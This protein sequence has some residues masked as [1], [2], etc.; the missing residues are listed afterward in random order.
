MPNEAAQF[1][2]SAKTLVLGNPA[3]LQRAHRLTEVLFERLVHNYRTKLLTEILDNYATNRKDY[4]RKLLL[5]Y[6]STLILEGWETNYL[7]DRVVEKFFTKDIRKIERRTFERFLGQFDFKFKTF[8]VYFGVDRATHGYFRKLSMPMV[9]AI[10]HGSAPAL[11][12][13]AFK[14]EHSKEPQERFV[15]CTVEKLDRK[16]ATSAALEILD[17]LT[18]L[19]T[20][21][22]NRS[23]FSWSR[24]GY[25]M[26]YRAA[27][28]FFEQPTEVRFQAEVPKSSIATGAKQKKQT[29]IIMRTMKRES[30]HRTLSALNNMAL[31]QRTNSAE[32]QLVLM[33]SAIEML[34]S[35]PPDRMPRIEFFLQSM[36]PCICI[37]YARRYTCSIFDEIALHYPSVARKILNGTSA[38]DGKDDHTRFA[39]FMFHEGFAFARIALTGA[40]ESNPLLQNR[41]WK[42]YENF[43]DPACLEKAVEGHELRVKW[44]ISRIY[45]ARNSLVHG[46][47]RPRYIAPITLNCFEYFKTVFF[48]ILSRAEKGGSQLETEYLIASILFDYEAERTKLEQ[49]RKT[50]RNGVDSNSFLQFV[51]RA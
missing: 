35:D 15:R 18:A 47:D 41:I 27:V 49:M 23:T 45:R 46:G 30:T 20:L 32:N 4:L 42:L 39:Y 36:I 25:A 34:I 24:V 10:K 12:V 31:A 44:Q 6:F 51:E 14:A 17:T 7:Y 43:A 13:G 19:T 33:W 22:K 26:T 11:V 8:H 48:T 5:N 21:Q 50:M 28:G 2:L 1:P 16:G 37:N 3:D 40:L 9:D 38:L 29:S